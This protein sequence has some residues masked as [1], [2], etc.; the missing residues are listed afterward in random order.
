M[1][2]KEPE[3]VDFEEYNRIKSLKKGD[4]VLVKRKGEE[5]RLK[6]VSKLRDKFMGIPT[7]RKVELPIR[8]RLRHVLEKID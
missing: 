5:Y 8:F 6:I 7:D 4:H 2:D 1:D 3:T